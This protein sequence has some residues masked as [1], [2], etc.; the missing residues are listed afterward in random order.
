MSFSFISLYFAGTRY[1]CSR[2]N[3]TINLGSKYLFVLVVHSRNVHYGWACSWR[4]KHFSKSSGGKRLYG[5]FELSLSYFIVVMRNDHLKEETE[6]NVNLGRDEKHWGSKRKRKRKRPKT[7]STLEGTKK[8][9]GRS[10][11]IPHHTRLLRTVFFC[12]FYR[13]LTLWYDIS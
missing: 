12:S 8:I 2:N 1:L 13:S 11:T 10:A 6:N 9:E 7:M 5:I 3:Q 4:L